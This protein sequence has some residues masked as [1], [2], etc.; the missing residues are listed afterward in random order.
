MYSH[1]IFGDTPAD[2]ETSD[3]ENTYEDDTS[4]LS[5]ASL[6]LSDSAHG[7]ERLFTILPGPSIEYAKWPA[8][9]IPLL[10]TS[11]SEQN[12]HLP[13]GVLHHPAQGE[14]DLMHGIQFDEDYHM[15]DMPK[16]C[17]FTSLIKEY[18]R[19]VE[20]QKYHAGFDAKSTR[21]WIYESG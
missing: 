17:V 19:S 6:R 16:K 21:A 1:K 8:N 18:R 15:E 7:S 11:L 5:K 4:H 9:R 3:A 13:L 10:A 12:R 2:L 14:D 20:T